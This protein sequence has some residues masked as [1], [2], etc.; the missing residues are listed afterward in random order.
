MRSTVFIV[1][2]C[3][4]TLAAPLVAG[5]NEWF[6]Y[7]AWGGDADLED[8]SC[9][10]IPGEAGPVIEFDHGISAKSVQTMGVWGARWNQSQFHVC[11]PLPENVVVEDAFVHAYDEE[12]TSDNESLVVDH[13]ATPWASGSARQTD[14][15]TPWSWVPNAVASD[16]DPEYHVFVNGAW[17]SQGW[18]EIDTNDTGRATVGFQPV[19]PPS[20]PG[21]QEDS[22]I[23]SGTQGAYV[24]SKSLPEGPGGMIQ[25]DFPL[26]VSANRM[27]DNVTVMNWVQGLS[28]DSQ[29]S[30]E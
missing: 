18:D 11:L 30:V 12:G 20:M 29:T 28:Y 24:A 17:S 25:V 7:D 1:P 23:P 4:L 27:S 22:A 8:V 6:V 19:E 13:S 16:A 14:H 2:L 21:H 15:T 9:P 5:E 26:R 10:S 3:V